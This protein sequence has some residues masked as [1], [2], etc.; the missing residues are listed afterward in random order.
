MLHGYAILSFKNV[1]SKFGFYVG[2][3]IPAPF[4]SHIGSPMIAPLV[5]SAGPLGSNVTSRSLEIP[6]AKEMVLEYESLQSE[7]PFDPL[8]CR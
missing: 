2:I 1:S 3:H 7:T 6:D 5:A 8:F 4:C